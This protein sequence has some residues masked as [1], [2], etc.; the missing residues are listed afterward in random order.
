M[1]AP[2]LLIGAAP[3]G[4]DSGA[5][6][7]SCISAAESLRTFSGACWRESGGWDWDG[8]AMVV[9]GAGGGRAAT[10][11]SDDD[12]AELACSVLAADEEDD[13]PSSES[14]SLSGRVGVVDDAEPFVIVEAA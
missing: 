12:E 9:V 13:V 6:V 1:A 10:T 8:V 5:D 4:S 7:S 11:S 14:S 2:L 3:I